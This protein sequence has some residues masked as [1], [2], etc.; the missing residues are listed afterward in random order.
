MPK[1]ITST[2][3]E[4]DKK[5]HSHAKYEAEVGDSKQS[6]FYPQ[7]KFKQWGNDSN[8]SIRLKEDI[9]DSNHYIDGDMIKWES[10]VSDKTVEM[11]EVT[12]AGDPLFENGGFEFQITY[13]SKPTSNVLEFSLEHKKARYVY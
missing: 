12:K 10:G 9:K 1:K 11:Y 4:F 6:E 3:Y 13:H 8:I 5:I 2:T 7:V